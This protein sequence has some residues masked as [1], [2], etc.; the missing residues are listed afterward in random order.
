MASK[1][2]G[3]CEE[4]FPPQPLRQYALL[5]DG[6]RG[7][8]VGPRGDF[9]W[10]CVPRWDSDAV[11]STLIG[12]RGLYAVS[13]VGRYVWGGYYEH[14]SLIWRS[15]WVTG[16][17]VVECRE[18]LAF[19]GDPH[20]AV[21]MRRLSAPDRPVRVRVLLEPAAGFGQDPLRRLRCDDDGVWSGH[22]GDLRVRWSGGARARPEGAK[23]SRLVMDLTVEP[24][25]HHDLV[26][27]IG[28]QALP[29][30]PPR[31]GECWQATEDAWRRAVPDLAGTIARRDARHAYAVLRGLTGSA[32]GMVAASTTSLPERA[33][34]GRNYD[35]R[36]VWIRDQCYAGQAV[37]T[38]GDVS[39]LDDAVRFVTARLHD[40]GPSLAPAYTVDGRRIP[41]QR[42]LDLPGYPGGYDLVGN[43]VSKQFQLD[44]FGEAL[45]L[46]AAA[47]RHGRLDAD[48]RRAADIAADAIARRWQQPDAGVWELSDRYWAHSRLICAAGLRAMAGAA[49]PGTA[50]GRWIAL[51]DHLV[52][53]TSAR[54]LH[55]SGRW[56]RSPEDAGLDGSLLLP[57][58]R[59][60]L[61]GNDP[62]TIATLR[63]Y[64]EHLTED[65]FAYRFRH[66][67]RPLEAAEGAFL[68]C[69]FITALAEHQQGNEVSALRWFERN[70]AACGPAGLFSEEY[71]VS[72][73]QLRG[74]LPQAFV[75]ALMLECAA[76]LSRP[77]PGP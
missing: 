59:G 15:R 40:D 27:E 5:A 66:D 44:A 53:E 33:D 38:A 67:D 21:I 16:E 17:G 50:G 63:A 51:A 48:G 8:L 18:A 72:Q 42:T 13:P 39:L 52:A 36:Y 24:G 60:A 4:S 41:D 55:P 35:Y 64:T 22:T 25:R 47:A 71:D 9:A 62:R 70:R 68:L 46:L 6:E 1:L 3:T 32:G 65:H 19:P 23:G 12:G 45:L 75:H 31:P 57:P 34:E 69:G 28:D 30:A 73:R 2:A 61:P 74:N 14:G 26:L 56:Q 11:F 77:W 54:C 58:L 7:I 76:R 20:R 29:S 49:D 43:Q 10:M 37:A